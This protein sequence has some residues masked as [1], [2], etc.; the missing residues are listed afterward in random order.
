MG[1]CVNITNKQI[2]CGSHLVVRRDIFFSYEHHAL[3][4][5]NGWVIHY[6]DGIIKCDRL[7]TFSQ[8]AD[9]EIRHYTQTKY[10]S[11]QA[12]QRA[13]S[14]I[15]EEEYDLAFNNCE[16]FVNW[17]LNGKKYSIQANIGLQILKLLAL[18]CCLYYV[19]KGYIK[20]RNPNVC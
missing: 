17:C 6:A 12:I 5:G 10:S 13:F 4:I 11:S 9:F 7:A 2:L 15:G 8:N 16:H 1:R 14:K 18:A 20:S 3:Y 19:I